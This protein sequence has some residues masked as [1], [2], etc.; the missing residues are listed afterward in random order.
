MSGPTELSIATGVL[1]DSGLK[2]A[3]VLTGTWGLSLCLRRA[4]ASAR[5]ALWAAS[6][7]ALPVLPLLAAQRGAE[8]AVDAPWVM[9][10]WALGALLSASPMLLGLLRLVWLRHSARLG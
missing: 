6:L 2:A 9:P 4:S 8:I 10:L 7:G 3:L 5:H 1:L